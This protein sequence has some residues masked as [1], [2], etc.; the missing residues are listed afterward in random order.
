MLQL[1]KLEK[2]VDKNAQ[3]I[4]VLTGKVA[5]DELPVKCRR[6]TFGK[7]GIV[8]ALISFVGV[9]RNQLPAEPHEQFVA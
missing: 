8:G 4:V 6:A 1:G 3:L 7:V 2:F 9:N 5:L